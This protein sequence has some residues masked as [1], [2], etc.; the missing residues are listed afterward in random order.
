MHHILDIGLN[1][2]C[3]L[4]KVK[5]KEKYLYI[6]FGNIITLQTILRNEIPWNNNFKKHWKK[7]KKKIPISKINVAC[8]N[9]NLF[10]S[11]YEPGT[12]ATKAYS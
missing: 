11:C 4:W 9:T 8:S 12:F 5:R 7:K 10:S 1:F 3:G 2:G 6:V